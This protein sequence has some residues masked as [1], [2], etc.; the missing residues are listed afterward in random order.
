MN[1]VWIKSLWRNVSVVSCCLIS[2]SGISNAE[3]QSLVVSSSMPNII[4]ILADDLGYGEVGFN[5]QDKIKTPALDSMARDGVVLSNFYAGAPVCGPSRA[6]LLYGQHTGHC[7]IRGNPAWTISGNAP[8]MTE[9]AVILPELMK[10][11]GYATAVFGKW[12]MNENLESNTG[13]PLKQG[14]DEFVGFN[15]HVEAHYHWPEFVWDGY[16][17]MP[18][19]DGGKERN[20]E[21]RIRYADDV[22]QE[23][24]LDYIERKADE[25]FFMYLC[26]TIPHKGYT[27]PYDSSDPYDGLGWPVKEGKKGHYEMDRNMV[28][29]IAGMITRMDGYIAELRAKLEAEGIAD[30][31]LVFFTSDNG[32][33]WMDDFFDSNGPF[34]GKKRSLYEGGIRMPTVAVWPDAIQKNTTISSPFAFWDMM[35]T[36]CD[37]AGI[38]PPQETGGISFYPSLRGDSARQQQH[39]LLYWE[40]NEKA[41]PIQAIRQGKWKAVRAWDKKKNAFKP[42]EIYDL[43]ADPG[44]QRNLASRYPERVIRM[45]KAIDDSRTE[46]AEF[47]LTYRSPNNK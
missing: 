10:K 27:V 43:E 44:E 32:H 39:D 15:T 42:L 23:C 25:P 22:F 26:Y 36:L 13:H 41:G 37:I 45:T 17:K 12:G 34:Q 30:N 38:E 47:P 21:E 18:L 46:N 35:P 3:E 40:F 4:F 14:F 19:L 24:A 8:E 9:E 31:T 7:P 29:A 5:G 2:L 6:T 28:T 16:A 11:A 33:E 20:F 1:Y